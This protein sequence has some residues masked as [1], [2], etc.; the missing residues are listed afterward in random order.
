MVK[1]SSHVEA[2]YGASL[3]CRSHIDSRVGGSFVVSG[4]KMELRPMVLSH[5]CSIESSSLSST[6]LSTVWV[7]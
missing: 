6:E 7:G 5:V 4:I 3:Y 1:R 2:V